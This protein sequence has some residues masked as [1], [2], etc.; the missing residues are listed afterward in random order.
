LI[1]YFTNQKRAS[2]FQ[3][4]QLLSIEE[5][6]SSE[7]ST[8]KKNQKDYEIF[9]EQVFQGKYGDRYLSIQNDMQAFMSMAVG[10]YTE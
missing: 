8:F 6:L 5:K 7:V 9:K 4:K 1:K 3:I 2:D 10:D